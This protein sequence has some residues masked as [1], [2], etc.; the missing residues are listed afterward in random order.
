MCIRD[1]EDGNPLE[2]EMMSDE[3]YIAAAAKRRGL[4]LVR[5][6][7]YLYCLNLL[8]GKMMFECFRRLMKDLNNCLLYTSRCV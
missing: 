2:P 6:I 3:Y 7:G 4:G 8:T 5:F 1:R